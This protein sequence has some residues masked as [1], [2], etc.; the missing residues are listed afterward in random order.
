M[1]GKSVI[2]GTVTRPRVAD[3]ATYSQL[4]LER[5]TCGSVPTPVHGSSL[6][7][8]HPSASCCLMR[9]RLAQTPEIICIK[10]GIVLRFEDIS[11]RSHNLIFKLLNNNTPSSHHNHGKKS[12]ENPQQSWTI[13]PTSNNTCCYSVSSLLLQ[14]TFLPPTIHLLP[15]MSSFRSPI[16]LLSAEL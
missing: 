4:P 9:F 10:S 11:Q 15:E 12:T 14:I 2:C 3:Q 13:R 1:G 16:T 6:G 5:G 7:C 8:P